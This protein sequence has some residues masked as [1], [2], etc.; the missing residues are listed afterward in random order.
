MRGPQQAYMKK[1]GLLTNLERK[2]RSHHWW[3]FDPEG[4]VEGFKGAGPIVIVGDQPSTSD[5]PPNHPNRLLFYGTLASLNIGGAHLTDVI[6]RRGKA[7]ASAK[8]LPADFDNHLAILRREFRIVSPTRIIALGELAERWLRNYFPACTNR[9][10]G[11]IHFAAKP[12]NRTRDVAAEF[13]R[14]MRAAIESPESELRYVRA[15]PHVKYSLTGTPK[16]TMPNQMFAIY[17]LLRLNV[18]DQTTELSEPQVMKLVYTA[19]RQGELITKQRPWR[20]WTYYFPK[21]LNLGLLR[22]RT[23]STDLK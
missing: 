19:A 20:I 13:K 18:T 9:V 6:K 2:I 21:L 16:T 3:T 23:D 22:E 10:C 5:W 1:V 11:I 7:S 12:S 4:A 17:E 15:R 14:Q 8:R